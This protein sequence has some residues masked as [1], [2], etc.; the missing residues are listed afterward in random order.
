VPR[1]ICERIAR[2]LSA[3]ID[4]LIRGIE[5]PPEQVILSTADITSGLCSY[6]FE[7][8]IDIPYRCHRCG[9]IY[10]EEHRLPERHN[11]PGGKGSEAIMTIPTKTPQPATQVPEGVII[12]HEAPC[13]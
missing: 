13:G 10:C 5:L 1:E 9:G 7:K 3:K 2:R 8:L 6:C 11:C 12:L 4:A